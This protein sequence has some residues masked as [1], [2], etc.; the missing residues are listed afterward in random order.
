M[1]ISSA[2]LG[3]PARRDVLRAG[4]YGLGL[5]VV[6]WGATPLLGSAHTPPPRPTTSASWWWWNCRARMT[7]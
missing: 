3:G 1:T 2:K 5:G 4:V 6:G 7:D